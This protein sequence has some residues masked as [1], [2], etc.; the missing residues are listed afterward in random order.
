[1]RGNLSRSEFKVLFSILLK[2]YKI[3]E[4]ARLLLTNRAKEYI[5]DINTRY[6]ADSEIRTLYLVFSAFTIL[7]AKVGEEWICCIF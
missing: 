4:N 3:S 7:P 5:I 1:M 6:C 2:F